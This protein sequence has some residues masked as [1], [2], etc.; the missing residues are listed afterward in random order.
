MSRKKQMVCI[1]L[2]DIQY[3][4]IREA[5][6]QEKSQKSVSAYIRFCLDLQLDQRQGE[7]LARRKKERRGIPA[8]LL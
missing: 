3:Q 2:S 7:E 6:E 1:R 4:R 5:I 8:D